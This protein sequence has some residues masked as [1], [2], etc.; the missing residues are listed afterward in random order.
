MLAP[1]ATSKSEDF[2]RQLD[3]FMPK[4]QVIVARK[5]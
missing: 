5:T 3:A 4:S 1:L 2:K